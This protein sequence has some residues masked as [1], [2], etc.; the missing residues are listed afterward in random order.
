[1]VLATSNLLLQ[2][3]IFAFIQHLK[4][5]SLLYIQS[6]SVQLLVLQIT[7]AVSFCRWNEGKDRKFWK[8]DLR[9]G[10]E[11]LPVSHTM[12]IQECME[13]QFC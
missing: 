1:M 7:T 6:I 4:L 11:I 9:F 5:Q 12:K 2:V 3:P 13:R 8:H 10:C